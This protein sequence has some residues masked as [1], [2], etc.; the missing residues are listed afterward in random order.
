MIH[1]M[2]EFLLKALE[3]GGHLPLKL[4][5]RGCLV[6]LNQEMLRGLEAA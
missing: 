4:S 3:T 1:E 6:S 2:M 5:G